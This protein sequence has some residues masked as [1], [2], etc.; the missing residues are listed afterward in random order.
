M[1]KKSTIAG[2][3]VPSVLA[4]CLLTFGGVTVG[5]THS[6]NPWNMKI[7]SEFKRLE[8]D[9]EN[10]KETLESDD[11]KDVKKFVDANGKGRLV[12]G[13]YCNEDECAYTYLEDS[14]AHIPHSNKKLHFKCRDWEAVDMYIKQR[15]NKK[16]QPNPKINCQKGSEGETCNLHKGTVVI[17]DSENEHGN[18]SLGQVK[19]LPLDGT[20]ENKAND[21]LK[22]VLKQFNVTED[23][24]NEV[25]HLFWVAKEK[26]KKSDMYG[27]QLPFESF[28]PSQ[29]FKKPIFL[30]AIN[31]E[32]MKQFVYG[33]SEAN[34]KVWNETVSRSLNGDVLN[35]KPNPIAACLN[36]VRV[37]P[38]ALSDLSQETN[39]SD[40]IV[41][42]RL[43]TFKNIFYTLAGVPIPQNHVYRD[44]I[45]YNET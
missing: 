30:M 35:D 16:N 42:E 25:L 32:M 13:Q 18:A 7:R 24:F 45:R 4:A 21:Y 29:R 12:A 34:W 26:Y 11:F 41:I 6:I 22:N 40:Q 37:S 23:E 9:L 1:A 36:W 14:S 17:H 43:Q 27:N 8:K 10:D 2:I 5:K 28:K 20:S 39:V 15:V 3:T 33:Y 44:S 38:D 19:K 31:E